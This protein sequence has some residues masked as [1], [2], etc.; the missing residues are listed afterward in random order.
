MIFAIILLLPR[1]IAIYYFLDSLLRTL[2]RRIW[3]ELIISP[4][5]DHCI[6]SYTFLFSCCIS[7]MVIAPTKQWAYWRHDYILHILCSCN[8]M[9]CQTCPAPVIIIPGCL[10]WS[11]GRNSQNRYALR[12]GLNRKFGFFLEGLSYLYRFHFLASWDSLW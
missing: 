8:K 11:L 7:Y 6:F 2:L 5:G 9:M 4:L 12:L 10:A 3:T 1:N